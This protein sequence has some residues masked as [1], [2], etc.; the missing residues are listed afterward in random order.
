MLLGMVYLMLPSCRSSRDR[1]S[2]EPE[3]AHQ[4]EQHCMREGMTGQKPPLL[5]AMSQQG[6][7]E[8][9]KGCAL[10]LRAYTTGSVGS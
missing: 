3:E 6:R 7:C 8:G 4:Q 5:S 2:R 10:S 1:L 9:A